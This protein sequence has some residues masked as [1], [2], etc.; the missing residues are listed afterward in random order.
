MR[1]GVCLIAVSAAMSATQAACPP[2][3]AELLHLKVTL[4]DPRVSSDIETDILERNPFE[5]S[6]MHGSTKVTIKGNAVK[7]GGA[8]YHLRLIIAEWASP[9]NN[10]T[11]TYELDLAPGKPWAGGMISSFAFQ[12]VVLLSR[13]APL[14]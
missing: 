5:Y 1:L 6:E 10:S 12:R 2:S 7:A 9:K 11:E 3:H 14:H 4:H 13:A 8:N